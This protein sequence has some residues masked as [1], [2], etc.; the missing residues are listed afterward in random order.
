MHGNEAAGMYHCLQPKIECLQTHS[1]FN[2]LHHAS[3]L[4]A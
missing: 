3:I 4:S 1:R 2:L